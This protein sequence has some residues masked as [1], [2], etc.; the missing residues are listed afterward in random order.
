[1]CVNIQAS[2]DAEARALTITALEQRLSDAESQ[3]AQ[4]ETRLNEQVSIF[5]NS[6]LQFIES[7]RI[8]TLD[9]QVTAAHER[10]S[11]LQRQ[12]SLLLSQMENLTSQ[13]SRYHELTSATE[14]NAMEDTEGA[15]ETE[16][17]DKSEKRVSELLEVVQYLRVQKEI[18]EVLTF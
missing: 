8:V 2:I 9:T 18:A 15:S 5:S 17:T 16:K 11:A 7:D 1:M 6:A 13:A 12:N 3:A 14:S 10:L 4:R